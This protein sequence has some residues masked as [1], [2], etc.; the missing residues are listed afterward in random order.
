MATGSR[1]E[2]LRGIGS[3][4]FI[5]TVANLTV[6]GDLVVLGE[7]RALAGTGSFFWEDADANAE[8]WA[9]E[10]PSGT[11]QHV[12]VLGVG[13]GLD[14]V[15]LGLFDGITQPTM[16]VL[17]ADRDSFIAVDFSGDDAAR[18][19]SN[20]AMAITSSSTLT[21]TPTTDVHI[22][23]GTGL[24]IG[25]TAQVTANTL[26][27]LQLLGTVAVDSSAMIGLFSSSLHTTPAELQ[28][29]KSRSATIGG[30]TIV[31]DDDV[32]GRLTFLPADGVDLATISATF[33]AEVED[34]SPAAGD[35][36]TAFVFSTMA[37]GGVALTEKMRLEADG[38][39]KFN[40]ASTISTGTGDLKLS[41]YSNSY[42]FGGPGGD[43]FLDTDANTFI[44]RA[45]GGQNIY[46]RLGDNGGS[47]GLIIEDDN[48]ADVLKITSDGDITVNQ[49]STW[50][51]TSG[52]IVLQPTG[53]LVLNSV[54]AGVTADTGSSQDDG[55][56]TELITQ[57][58]VCATAGDAVTLPSATAGMV[59]I[60]L[61]DGAESCDVFPASGDNIDEAGA[62][63]AHA[64]AVNKNAMFI[65]HDATHWSVI[66]TA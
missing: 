44:I 56:I 3:N 57:V 18:L 39:L 40:Q 22:S 37:G 25:H 47:T 29:V 48:A 8:Y 28:F 35:I 50:S 65:A 51:T 23:N 14:G 34:G 19:R 66:L 13:V 55:A 41:S 61:N 12:P 46:F 60:V 63:V 32:I 9:F 15:D 20:A 30:F 53:T 64:L 31:D 33:H 17:D 36:G 7:N 10:L 42:V 24:V 52:N 1:T 2:G 21:L 59:I 49:E 6:T 5:R 38:G 58:S 26:A 27:E 16:V 54:N 43:K 11:S 4:G 45:R 62:N